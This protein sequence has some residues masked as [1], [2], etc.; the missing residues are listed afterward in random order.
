MICCATQLAAMDIACEYTFDP[1]FKEIKQDKSL[2]CS[3]KHIELL[4]PWE[5]IIKTKD[6]QANISDQVKTV[7]FANQKLNF[8]P[9]GLEN[10]FHDLKGLFFEGC[11][12]HRVEQSNFKPFTELEG[13][14]LRCNPLLDTLEKGLFDYNLKLTYLNFHNNNF[15]HIDANL[16]KSLNVLNSVRF[17][18]CGCISTTIEMNSMLPFK[19]EFQRK[20]QNE[21]AMQRQTEQVVQQN[22]HKQLYDEVREIKNQLEAEF[23]PLKQKARPNKIRI[24]NLNKIFTTI[25]ELSNNVQELKK[26]ARH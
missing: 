22:Y 24:Y 11:N 23:Y 6:N 8:I 3:V 17:F 26:Q 15:K 4:T 12:I 10:V 2:S 13:L 14:W 1:D 20:C 25:E 5:V 16:F 19:D 18:K 9:A 21:E 7:N